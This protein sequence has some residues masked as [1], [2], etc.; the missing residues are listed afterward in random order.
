MDIVLNQCYSSA[1]DFCNLLWRAYVRTISNHSR[2][3]ALFIV[4]IS[5]FLAC[6]FDDTQHYV[7]LKLFDSKFV[8]DFLLF[9]L[10][11]RPQR[12]YAQTPQ[13]QTYLMCRHCWIECV[14]LHLTEY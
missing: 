14:L 8:L 1:G 11:A 13:T 6:I 9:L 4:A 7:V 10:L 5:R 3:I 12:A 2:K